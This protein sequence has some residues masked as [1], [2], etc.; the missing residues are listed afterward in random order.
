MR[1]IS[2]G[3]HSHHQISH[4]NYNHTPENR[5][6]SRFSHSPR[7]NS[8]DSDQS[9]SASD[10][11]SRRM[12]GRHCRYECRQVVLGK[13]SEREMFR[14]FGHDTCEQT[15][16]VFGVGNEGAKEVSKGRRI[17]EQES[18]AQ[19]E[20]SERDRTQRGVSYRLYSRF[21]DSWESEAGKRRGYG[22]QGMY[23]NRESERFREQ[24]ETLITNPSP[25]DD[26]VNSDFLNTGAIPSRNTSNLQSTDSSSPHITAATT[27]QTSPEPTM[28]TRFFEPFV[29]SSFKS[30]ERLDLA[31]EYPSTI[32][33]SKL[34]LP[35]LPING[36]RSIRPESNVDAFT[37]KDISKSG[38][39]GTK[40][41]DGDKEEVKEMGKH[42][43][44]ELAHL[45]VIW[46]LLARCERC[47]ISGWVRLSC[48]TC[49]GKKD[50]WKQ[51][52]SCH[53]TGWV[54]PAQ[55]NQVSISSSS[56]KKKQECLLCGATPLERDGFKCPECATRVY[57]PCSLDGCV[58]G[59]YWRMVEDWLTLAG[60]EVCRQYMT[61]L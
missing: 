15:L 21:T 57:K 22:G 16:Y 48:S 20:R 50:N 43:H 35:S 39:S 40:A 60:K 11:Q 3:I 45:K 34:Q 2:H 28:P 52:F 26:T 29:L 14:V 18:G 51:C 10:L 32:I 38:E 47:D 42:I 9:R 46:S 56:S 8:Y 61:S 55:S 13:S 27:E 25:S 30:P 31:T 53:G 7:Q 17:Y 54:D 5:D 33:P 49:L 41:E 6:G 19:Y 58:R 1:H 23:V 12:R 44:S 37:P 36:G 24:T 4:P 59:A